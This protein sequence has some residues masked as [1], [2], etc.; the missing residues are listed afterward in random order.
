MSDHKVNKDT[1]ESINYRARKTKQSVEYYRCIALLKDTSLWQSQVM[2]KRKGKARLSAKAQVMLT[3]LAKF[4]SQTKNYRVPTSQWK[5]C[6]QTC[7]L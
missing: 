3:Y 1:D 2:A 7:N 6:K 5:P 4:I